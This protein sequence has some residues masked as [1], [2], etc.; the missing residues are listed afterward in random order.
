MIKRQSLAV[1]MPSRRLELSLRAGETA[2][3]PTVRYSAA[4]RSG[5]AKLARYRRSGA[6]VIARFSLRNRDGIEIEDDLVNF[7]GGR[8][9]DFYG[10]ELDGRFQ[11]R[12]LE[13]FLFDLEGA[14]LFPGDAFYDEN[15]QAARST[16]IQ[17]RATFVF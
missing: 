12:Y 9:G 16:L 8:P 3:S 2:A 15:E 4:F 11:W 1:P 10:I 7:N 6:A 5:A 13:R 17:G 14:I